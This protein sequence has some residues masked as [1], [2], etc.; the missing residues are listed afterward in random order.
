M[1]WKTEELHN[2]LKE[3][4][5]DNWWVMIWA[6]V[7]LSPNSCIFYYFSWYL[8]IHG[9]LCIDGTKWT[10]SLLFL[11]RNVKKEKSH[12]FESTHI[13]IDTQSLSLSL[14]HTHTHTHTHLSSSVNSTSILRECS[15]SAVLYQNICFISLE[16]KNESLCA[17]MFTYIETS[18]NGLFLIFCTIQL[19]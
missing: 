14:S 16:P 3:D 1:D 2:C 4:R 17:P 9:I 8:W 10:M 19:L 18:D 7:Y 12:L 13:H 6:L 5:K 11:E 15:Y